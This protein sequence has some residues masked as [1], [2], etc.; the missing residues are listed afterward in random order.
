[1]S[2]RPASA[3]QP[4]PAAKKVKRKVEPGEVVTPATQ[5]KLR[6]KGETEV[7]LGNIMRPGNSLRS[8]NPAAPAR[9]SGAKPQHKAIHRRVS[10]VTHKGVTGTECPQS[11]PRPLLAFDPAFPVLIRAV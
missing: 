1:M 9:G 8:Q 2:L 3:T 7:T 11:C 6:R 5:G 4:D 10:C